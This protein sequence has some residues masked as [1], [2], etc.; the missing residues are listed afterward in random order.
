[1]KKIAFL[2]SLSLL[3]FSCKTAKDTERIVIASEKGDC[4]GVAPMKCLYMKAEGENDWEFFYDSIEGFNYEPGY[5]Y[6]IEVKKEAISAP[7][8]DQSSL[9]YTLVKEISKTKKTSENLP[10]IETEVLNDGHNAQNSLSY[11][12][13][14]EG[15][16]PCADCPGIDIVITLDYKGNYT[17][18]MTYQ[19]RKPENVFSTSGE[20]SWDSTGTV[21]TLTGKDDGEKFKVV[22]GAILMLDTEGKE[23]SG[24][25]AGMY[26]IK[27]TKVQ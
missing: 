2:L 25:N 1:M 14:Y 22:E 12:G 8:A 27:Q 6:V 23:I 3:V 24:S 9:K 4:V 26:R 5:E 18:K 19:D 17:K 15:T 10:K 21:I 20:F 16:I 13:T 11:A 7:A